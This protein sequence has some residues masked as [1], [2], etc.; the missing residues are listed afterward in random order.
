MRDVGKRQEEAKRDD[1]CRGNGK[2]L[3][4]GAAKNKDG[5]DGAEECEDRDKFDV[6][7]IEDQPC[8]LENRGVL[9]LHDAVRRRFP[10]ISV[11]M[12]VFL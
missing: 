5:D 12:G 7:V 4:P 1:N 8:G 6:D 3:Q 11:E 10:A 2:H 9:I